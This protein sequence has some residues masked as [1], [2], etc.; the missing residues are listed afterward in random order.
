MAVTTTPQDILTAAYGKSLKNK[1]G[2]IATE[3]TELLEVVIRALRGLYAAAA[4]VNHLFF[5]EQAAVT[6]AAGAW[7]R[8]ET[9]ESIFRIERNANTTGGSGAVG[10]EV[11]VVPFDDRAAESGKG[12]VYRFGQKFY[13]AGNAADPTGGELAFFYSRRPTSPASLTATLDAQWTETFNELL[14]LETALYLASKD[15]R[16]GEVSRLDKDRMAWLNLFVG[17]LEHETANERRRF[18]HLQR[19][20]VMTLIPLLAPGTVAGA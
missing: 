15:D 6:L 5:A 9:A 18:G 2:T 17:F 3:S 4:R 8:P 13:S 19:I 20:N 10:S 12:A 16:A 14:I 1:P 7:A 11:V